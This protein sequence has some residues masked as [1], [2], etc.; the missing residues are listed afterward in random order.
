[1]SSCFVVFCH[2]I[3]WITNPYSIFVFCQSVSQS[4]LGVSGVKAATFTL[5]SIDNISRVTVGKTF[6][7]IGLLSKDVNEAV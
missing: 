2:G 7:Q 1:M 6:N 5:Q 4:T 3:I